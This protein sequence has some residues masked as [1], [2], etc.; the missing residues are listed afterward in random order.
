MQRDSSDLSGLSS[1]DS[2]TGSTCL[3]LCLLPGQLTVFILSE[4]LLSIHAHGHS[5]GFCSRPI[6]SQRQLCKAA[7]W[8]TL[9]ALW[10]AGYS[11][12][13]SQMLSAQPE[14]APGMRGRELCS[15]KVSPSSFSQNSLPSP[16][17]WSSSICC[18]VQ[19]KSAF[20]IRIPI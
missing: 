15:Y 2:A 16:P 10:W 9:R 3:V 8:L 20:S 19:D 14:P 13:H 5:W 11:L 6:T 18:G 7:C 12:L 1:P 4:L 17:S